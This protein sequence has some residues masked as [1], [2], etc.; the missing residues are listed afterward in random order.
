LFQL[1][2]AHKTCKLD[3]RGNR[4]TIINFAVV[5]NVNWRCVKC[6]AFV[7]FMARIDNIYGSFVTSVV[8]K[9]RVTACRSAL[10]ERTERTAAR[11]YTQFD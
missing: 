10:G 8:N 4:T 3:K 11:H 7:V 5:K 9:L 2:K 1:F 6:V